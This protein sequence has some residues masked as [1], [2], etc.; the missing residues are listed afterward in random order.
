MT[1]REDLP[2]VLFLCAKNAG[3][4][5]MAAALTRRLAGDLVEVVTGGSAP[6]SELHEEVVEAMHEIGIDI[7]DAKPR[8]FTQEDLERADVIVT[9][10]CG[11]E[12]PYLPG[13]RYEDWDVADPA[14]KSLKEVR[15]IREEIA[16][17]VR[18]LLDS[19]A[20]P[21]PRL[22]AHPDAMEVSA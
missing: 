11:E 16:Y 19:L 17:R 13:K 20:L 9:M 15:Q 4:S 1:A 10:G 5:Q 12:C 2:V 21:T 22:R 6:S 3:R 8:R 7:T 14:G 18:A